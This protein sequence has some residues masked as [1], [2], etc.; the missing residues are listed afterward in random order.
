MESI[1]KVRIIGLDYYTCKRVSINKTI[2]CDGLHFFDRVIPAMKINGGKYELPETTATAKSDAD[3]WVSNQSDLLNSIIHNPKRELKCI[4]NW[5]VLSIKNVGVD[6]HESANLPLVPTKPKLSEI[7]KITDVMTR[8]QETHGEF[9]DEFQANFIHTYQEI[10]DVL[11]GMPID[12]KI[13]IILKSIGVGFKASTTAY[14]RMIDLYKEFDTKKLID[15]QNN[16][17]T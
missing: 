15:P 6:V 14:E 5:E 17:P 1:L 9:T 13:L 12:K 7:E 2:K 16:L 8:M 10:K 3:E 11:G 4:L